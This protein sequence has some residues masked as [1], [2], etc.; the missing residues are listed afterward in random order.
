MSLIGET[1]PGNAPADLI[2]EGSDA[3]FMADVIEASKVQPVI[4]DFWATW[5]GPC[6]TLGPALERQVMAAKGK[7]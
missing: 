2:K 6:K 1:T 5:C 3:G 4:V 7:V